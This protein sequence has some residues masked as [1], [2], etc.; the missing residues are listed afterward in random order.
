MKHKT[1]DVALWSTEDIEV[2][3]PDGIPVEQKESFIDTVIDVISD[4]FDAS[5]GVNWDVI[6]DAIDE[7]YKGWFE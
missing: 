4:N 5:I 1:F 7:T 3:L 6:N 2:N